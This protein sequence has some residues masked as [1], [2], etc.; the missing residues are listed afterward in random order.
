MGFEFFL[1][2]NN[3]WFASALGI[4]FGILT[5]ETF[6]LLMGLGISDVIDNFIDFDI[7]ADCDIDCEVG[8]ELDAIDIDADLDIDLDSNFELENVGGSNSIMGLLG[9]LGF[10][11]VPFLIVLSAFLASFGLAG[12]ILQSVMFT[13]STVTLPSLVAIPIAFLLSL[14]VTSKI[15]FWI[16]AIMPDDES[17]AIQLKD[18]RGKQAVI[19]LGTTTVTRPTEAKVTDRHGRVHYIRVIPGSEGDSFTKGDKVILDEFEGNTFKV[20]SAS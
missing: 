7:H 4:M 13:L 2:A 1:L 3:V 12:I 17:T 18:L 8:F 14:P 10:G 19:T 16:G 6:S 20:S 11:K 9:W 5:I 15:S